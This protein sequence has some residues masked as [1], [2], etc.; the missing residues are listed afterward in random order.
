MPTLTPSFPEFLPEW[1]ARQRWYTAKGRTPQ[2]RRVGGLRYQDPDGEV[3]VET[4]IVQDDGGPAPVV[5]QI[6]LSYRGA[7]VP[8]L[9]HALVAQAEHSELGPRWIYDGCHDPVAARLILTTILGGGSVESDGGD[10]YGRATGHRAG[11]AGAMGSH[12]AGERVRVLR[13]EQSNTSIIFEG[14]DGP[15]V[16]CKVFRVLGDGRNPDVVVQEALAAA[17][18]TRVPAPLGDLYGEWPGTGD[19]RR[20]GHLAYAQEFLPGVEDAWRVAVRAA[21]DGADLAERAADLGAAVA[22]VHR[23]LAAAFPTHEATAPVRSQLRATW[24]HRAT[25]ALLEVPELEEHRETIAAVFART[26]NVAWPGLQ[27]IHGDLHL[28]QVIEAP[29]RGW[30]LLDFEGEPLRPLAERTAPDLALRD[31]AGMLRSLDYA[32]GAA[33]REHGATVG[34]D[35]AAQARTA[36]LDGYAREA[37]HDPREDAEL[38]AALELDKALY[39]AVYE[40]RN[41]PDWLTIPVS[42]VRRL[43]GLGTQ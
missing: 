23:D 8:E 3:G 21:V 33:Q 4:W 9:E 17:G 30:L 14:E 43:L 27:R 16:I 12:T 34:E 20:H 38:L 6:P 10:Q 31:V 36:F 35:W 39:E 28:G 5:Y 7:P 41:R 42:G 40:A 1:V 29:G 26:E 24:R 11:G 37:G 13:G 25:A 18:S 2:L 22:S 15:P 19:Q 32:A